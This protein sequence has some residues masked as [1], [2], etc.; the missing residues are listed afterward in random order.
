[1]ELV[2]RIPVRESSPEV[3]GPPP[4]NREVQA[5]PF[6]IV[7]G[8]SQRQGARALAVLLCTTQQGSGAFFVDEAEAKEGGSVVCPSCETEHEVRGLVDALE[9]GE[10]AVDREGDSCLVIPTYAL[11]VNAYRLLQ[12]PRRKRA[13]S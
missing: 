12:S 10:L 13:R 2:E 1:M 7:T 9:S 5:S 11:L 6:A 8:L 4:S 3:A